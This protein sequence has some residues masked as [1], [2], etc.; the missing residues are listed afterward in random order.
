MDKTAAKDI[1]EFKAW[2]ELKGRSLNGGLG[3]KGKQLRILLGKLGL[4]FVPSAE[5]TDRGDFEVGERITVRSSTNP[6]NQDECEQFRD[7]F[8]FIEQIIEPN[9]KNPSGALLV[10]ML[11]SGNPKVLF[12]GK[13]PGKPTGIYRS[14]HVS[15]AGKK[16]LEVIYFKNKTNR[17]NLD[18]IRTVEDYMGRSKGTDDQRDMNYYTGD[19]DKYVESKSGNVYFRLANTG[20]RAGGFTTISEADDS[21]ILYVGFQNRRPKGWQKELAQMLA[22][23]K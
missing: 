17:T 15:G 23:N 4:E 11:V 19:C 21:L 5:P 3:Y 8:G 20:Q 14:K 6:L 22:Q 2:C 13:S 16:M 1:A 12:D 10:K 18:R 7:Q 9:D